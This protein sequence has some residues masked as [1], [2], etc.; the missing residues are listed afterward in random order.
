MFSSSPL[1]ASEII[2]QEFQGPRALVEVQ[3]SASGVTKEASIAR[4]GA[5]FEH[6]MEMRGNVSPHRRIQGQSREAAVMT[7]R[8]SKRGRDHA[9]GPITGFHD[10]PVSTKV[11]FLSPPHDNHPVSDSEALEPWECYLRAVCL[12]RKRTR[13]QRVSVC[14]RDGEA[15]QENHH[16]KAT[17]S[18]RAD[19]KAALR[20]PKGAKRTVHSLE[21][22]V[23]Q[24]FAL[25]DS[26]VIL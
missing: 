13:G 15:R 11:L 12:W 19:T 22:R 26:S 8:H 23:A 24:C 21:A 7:Q 10:A 18:T 2:A 25:P 9:R 14:K 20:L 5:I 4:A 3:R 16:A 1:S 6:G 17:R